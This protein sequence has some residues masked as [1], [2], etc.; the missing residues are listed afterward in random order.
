MSNDRPPPIYH[1]LTHKL[2]RWLAPQTERFVE[3]RR[4]LNF[5][6]LWAALVGMLIGVVGSLFRL[7]VQRLILQRT[8][9]AQLFSSTSI[10]SWLIPSLLAGLM[11]YVSFGL[12][13][14][15]APDTGGSGIPQ[16]EGTLDNLLP[17]DWRR[18]LP[19]KFLGGILSLGAGM[20]A[21]YEGPTIQMGGS[22]GKMVANWGTSLPSK[23]EF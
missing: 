19:I 13:R 7:I 6:L 22:M 1:K 2:G 12:M 20:V 8:Q 5:V 14:R 17:L 11:V 15:F 9:L 21:G 10:A 23:L 3:A 16:I 18:V 4:E